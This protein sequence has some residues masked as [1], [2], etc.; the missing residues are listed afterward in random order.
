MDQPL[1]VSFGLP[2]AALFQ[3]P[4]HLPDVAQNF[5]FTKGPWMAK[6]TRYSLDTRFP[7]IAAAF[8]VAV[9]LYFSCLNRER[10]NKPWLVARY[11]AFRGFVL[12]HNL[13]LALFSAWVFLSTLSCL[14]RSFS[15]LDESH[16][17]SHIAHIVCRLD[18]VLSL[19]DSEPPGQV[20]S[21]VIGESLR[22]EIERIWHIS[23]LFYLSKI[24]EFIDTA[25]I[26]ATGKESS[27][28]QTYHH[29][30]VVI[31]AWLCLRFKAPTALVGL[32]VNSAIHTAMVCLPRLFWCLGTHCDSQYTYYT[33]V[34][35]KLRPP[36]MVKATLTAMQIAQ[37]VFGFLTGLGYIFVKY[38]LPLDNARGYSV[39]PLPNS[40]HQIQNRTVPC[41]YKF[42]QVSAVWIGGI[43]LAPL[44]YMFARFFTRAYIQP[45]KE[46][47]Q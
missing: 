22:R 23:W 30:G 1:S 8:Y 46:K 29:S 39:Q 47:L 44:L 36:T 15:N 24:Y 4:N 20:F 28:L 38:S 32:L 45:H 43:Y 16:S 9:V 42:E 31:C 2:H 11:R 37:F 13:L 14:R 19:E 26:L 7:F 33:I 18:N 35:V 27:T 12:V 6:I 3:I 17:L 5:L 41:V 21:D 40:E 10:K 25:I 34:T